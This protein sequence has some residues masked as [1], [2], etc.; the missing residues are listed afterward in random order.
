MVDE[1]TWEE[2]QVFKKQRIRRSERNTQV[3]YLLQGAVRCSECGLIL[4]AQARWSS[5]ST[6]K[7]KL[8]EYNYNPPLRYYACGG[9]RKN[10]LRCRKRLFIKAEQIEALLWNEVKSVLQNPDLL[11]AG[12]KSLEA[13]E[14]GT[15]DGEIAGVE[16]ELQKVKSEEDRAIRLY[17]LGKIS[18]KQLDKQREFID[19]RMER[20]QGKL[21][22]FRARSMAEADKRDLVKSIVAWIGEVGEGLDDLTDEKKRDL[23]R[24]LLNETLIDGSNKRH[25]SLAIPVEGFGAFASPA[26]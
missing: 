25:I 20:L 6:Y 23:L 3:F 14:N 4:L 1:E 5:Q 19:G 16:R 17:V 22:E 24:L 26:S 12:I 2:A 21:S 18:E 13:R 8:Y 10:G 7:G 15:L 11:L 9:M